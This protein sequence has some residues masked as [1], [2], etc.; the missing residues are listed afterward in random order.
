[1]LILQKNG[2]S[3][4]VKRTGKYKT[5]VKSIVLSVCCPQVAPFS[6]EIEDAPLEQF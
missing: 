1:M 2:V 4:D 6:I 5:K 3:I